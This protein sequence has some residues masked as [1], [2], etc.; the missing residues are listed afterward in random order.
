MSD[1]EKERENCTRVHVAVCNYVC[2][3]VRGLRVYMH[4]YESHPQHIHSR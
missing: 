1:G 4:I 3:C 2:V